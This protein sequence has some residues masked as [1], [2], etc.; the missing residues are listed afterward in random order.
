MRKTATGIVVFVG[1]IELLI[2]LFGIITIPFPQW[3]GN[4]QTDMAM[5]GM[6]QMADINDSDGTMSQEEFQSLFIQQIEEQMA[7]QFNAAAQSNGYQANGKAIDRNDGIFTSQTSGKLQDQTTSVK[8]ASQA[9]VPGRGSSTS[10]ARTD[11]FVPIS[12]WGCLEDLVVEQGYILVLEGS[13]GYPLPIHMNDEAIADW[14]LIFASHGGYEPFGGVVYLFQKGE[15]Y[16]IGVEWTYLGYE[17][18]H[19]YWMA[20]FFVYEDFVLDSSFY[21]W[22]DSFFS[23]C[24]E[25]LIPGKEVD[26]CFVLDWTG[27]SPENNQDFTILSVRDLP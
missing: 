26:M 8:S 20:T 2:I 3:L 14:Y 13:I 25:G 16:C 1:I 17:D 21:P 5:D 22:V 15:M 18:C 11:V 4:S 12:E 19:D 23:I 27:C 10:T 24:D 7:A 6:Q 9:T